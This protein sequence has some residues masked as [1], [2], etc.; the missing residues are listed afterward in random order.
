MRTKQDPVDAAASP[1]AKPTGH[2]G[3][4]AALSLRF[5]AA[6]VLAS[7]AHHGQVRKGTAVPY[8]THPAHV[9]R[10]LDRHGWPEHVVI[11]GLLHDVLEDTKCDDASVRQRLR[12]AFRPLAGAPDEAEAFDAA[13]RH[14]I[15]TSFGPAVLRLVEAV[16]ERKTE[17]GRRRPWLDRKL[18][19]LETLRRGDREHAALKA[20]DLLHNLT[21]ITEDLAAWGAGVMTR[22]NAPPDRLIWSYGTA[23]AIV[24]ERLGPDDALAKEEAEAF[25][26]FER[27]VEDVCGIKRE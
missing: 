1:Q 19:A 15:Q 22:F 17:D 3:A 11:A 14:A 9:A 13:L 5:Q 16:S 25:R 4:G 26:R 6:L 21:C 20:A 2:D 23:S 12:E 24:F 10:I 18:E 8:I 27:T 7:A